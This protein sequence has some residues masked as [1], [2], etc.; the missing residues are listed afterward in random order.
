MIKFVNP[1]IESISEADILDKFVSKEGPMLYETYGL[2]C[3]VTAVRNNRVYRDVPIIERNS[4]NVAYALPKE[5][6]TK[7]DFIKLSSIRVICDTVEEAAAL[8]DA[9]YAAIKTHRRLATAMKKEISSIFE[10][11]E[12]ASQAHNS[13]TKL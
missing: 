2:P 5:D 1:E 11:L 13:G 10:E 4:D 8:M 9:N 7:T 6:W 12:A 3:L